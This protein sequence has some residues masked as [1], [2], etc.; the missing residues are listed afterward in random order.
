[1]RAMIASSNRRPVAAYGQESLFHVLGRT[2]DDDVDLGL[3]GRR[4]RQPSHERE[5][6]QV[7]VGRGLR[8]PV[9]DPAIEVKR[10]RFVRVEP[11][12]DLQPWRHVDLVFRVRHGRAGE[13][14]GLH[15]GRHNP[16]DHLDG[17]VDHLA[18]MTHVR[19]IPDRGGLFAALQVLVEALGRTAGAGHYE[20]D[21]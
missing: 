2:V 12:L 15:A 11:M 19:A 9:R 17:R 16:P 4:W 20:E 8:T 18:H 5:D 3:A 13:L 21:G 1:M 6:H 7:L 14:E 10:I